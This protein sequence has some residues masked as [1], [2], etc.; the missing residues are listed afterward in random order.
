MVKYPVLFYDSQLQNGV[1]CAAG[2]LYDSAK[3]GVI[4]DKANLQ[5]T[6]QNVAWNI[7]I[8]FQQWKITKCKFWLDS[9]LQKYKRT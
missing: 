3:K 8:V 4:W 1:N 9:A 2:L 7:K 6:L 5:K